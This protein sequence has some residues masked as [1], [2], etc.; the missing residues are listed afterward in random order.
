MSKSSWRFFTEGLNSH[1]SILFY[2]FESF[3]WRA[4]NETAKIGMQ[5]SKCHFSSWQ[6]SASHLHIG[7]GKIAWIKIRIAIPSILFSWFSLLWLLSIPKFQDLEEKKFSNKKV[8]AAMD[9][10]FEGLETFY[11]SKGIKTLEHHWT[12]CVE[13][14]GELGRRKVKK[15]FPE[16][17]WFYCFIE[18]PCI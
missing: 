2:T 11:F 5:I 3:I 15:N 4:A 18:Q 12:K 1:R 10:Y 13:L 9:E 16:K 17:R 8:I 6:H 7:N 14:Q